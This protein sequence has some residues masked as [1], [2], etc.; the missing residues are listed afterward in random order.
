MSEHPYSERFSNCDTQQAIARIIMASEIYRDY[1]DMMARAEKMRTAHHELYPHS[2]IAE[3]IEE[4]RKCRDKILAL[5]G[6]TREWRDFSGD[7]GEIVHAAIEAVLRKVG[8][9]RYC[10]LFRIEKAP[11]LSAIDTHDLLDTEK[12][13]LANWRTYL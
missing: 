7:P 4:A 2:L 6:T 3:I 1:K 5:A 11:S 8:L 10:W 13:L 9:R 12:E